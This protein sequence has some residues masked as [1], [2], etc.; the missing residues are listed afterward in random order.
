VKFKIDENLPFELAEELRAIGYDADTVSEERLSGAPDAKIIAA[1]QEGG[2]VL[3][4]MDK[5]I[6]DLR[7][8]PPSQFA[9]IVLFR[10]KRAGRLTTLNFVRYHL[11]LLCRKTE[12]AGRLVVVSEA[13]MRIR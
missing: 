3:L 12:L 8:Y 4:T 9:G 7:L 1:A 13:G 6:A 2:R 10:P 11:L 5:G